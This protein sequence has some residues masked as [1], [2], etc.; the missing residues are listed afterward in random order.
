M[1]T[2]K[3][4]DKAKPD[5]K[6]YFIWDEDVRGLALAVHPTKKSWHFQRDLW[7]EGRREK[8]VYLRLPGERSLVEARQWAREQTNIVERGIDPTAPP[9]APAKEGPE[10]W[11]VREMLNRRLEYMK[12]N[13]YAESSFTD[14]E[15]VVRYL[16]PI[17]E[18]RVSD[19]TRSRCR[20]VHQQITSS[21]LRGER[22]A[23]SWAD[24]S[25]N[26]LSA[27]WVYAKRKFDDENRMP[28]ESE[29]PVQG[30]ERH[31]ANK[32][33]ASIQSVDLPE[34]AAIVDALGNPVR[35]HMHWIGMLTGLRKK[36]LLAI[37]K[38]WV[39]GD[40]LVIPADKMKARREFVCP[41][42]PTLVA[43][44]EQA[45]AASAFISPTSIFLFPSVSSASGHVEVDDERELEKRGWPGKL[46][47]KT[48]R[49]QAE[50]IGCPRNFVSYLLDHRA[51]G[52]DGNY[53]HSAELFDD[54]KE[55]QTKIGQRILKCCD[56]D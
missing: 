20:E 16:T 27:A 37:E 5:T 30:A 48:Y 21:G 29:N 55:W 33:Q 19:L 53:V 47:R 44:M 9:P 34:W 52:L 28:H 56:M 4:A 54:L 1:L 6:R 23:P 38:A 24:K 50:R 49:T 39:Q 15:Y 45:L 41:L 13:G 14:F 18:V 25:M 11:T 8:T 26:Y 43:R 12:A 2:Q 32:V 42:S 7:R 36:T 22:G 40:R 3:L 51:P 10:A 31:G 17:L 46:R 35:R